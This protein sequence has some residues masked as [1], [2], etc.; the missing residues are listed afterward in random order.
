[1]KF[2]THFSR[3]GNYILERGYENGKRFQ[4][5]TEYNPKKKPT[6]KLFRVISYRRFN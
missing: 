4:R 1:M 5:R 3:A 6:S 2:Y